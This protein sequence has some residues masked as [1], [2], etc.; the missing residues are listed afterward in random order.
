MK[1]KFFTIGEWVKA[2]TVDG[3]LIIGYIEEVNEESKTAKIRAV[4]TEQEAIAGKT[5]ETLIRSV[6]V[7][8]S[9]PASTKEDLVGLID[10][11]LQTRDEKWFQELTAYLSQSKE[12]SS[13]NKVLKPVNVNNRTHFPYVK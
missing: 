8:P 2:K 1:K 12:K 7:L 4:Q 5:I 13:K 6:S 11:A 9:T 10:L 3:E